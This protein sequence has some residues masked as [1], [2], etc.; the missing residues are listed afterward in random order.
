[1]PGPRTVVVVGAG[2]AGLAV[3]HEL[4]RADLPPGPVLVVGS[5]QSGCQIA[6]E[7][8]EAGRE[9]FL[10]CGRAPW[11]NRRI[12]DHDL[13]WWTVETGYMDVR[14]AELPTPAARLAGNAVATGHGGGH[15][16]H[17]RTLHGVGV[18][19]LG[20]LEGVSGRH[21]RFA[22]VHFLRTRKSSLLLGVGEDATLVAEGIAAAA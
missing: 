15:D 21:A 10:A 3:S 11:V 17:L 18:R 6:E 9:V 8:R 14:V 16:L 19:L 12:G 22:G 1:M 7:L 4:E 2:Q 20:H 5:G 13:S